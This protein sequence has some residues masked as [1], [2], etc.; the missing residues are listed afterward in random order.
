MKRIVCV[1]C[2]SF[3]FSL[4]GC[5]WFKHKPVEQPRI[6][7]RV[8]SGKILN[9]KRLK[10]GGNIVI[11]PFKAGAGVEATDELDKLSLMIVK[12]IADT[13][14]NQSNN[15]NILVSENANKADLILEGHITSLRQPSKLNRLILRKKKKDLGVK[16]KMIDRT[17]GQTLM[18]FSHTQESKN[19]K[20]N[21]QDLA[22][23]LGTN[24]GF[25]ILSNQDLKPGK[26]E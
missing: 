6:V 26:G 25:F 20:A 23:Q 11:L 15:F 16:G 8:N 24:I 2:V 22:Y 5:S 7:A 1:L 13:L 12:G 19:P 4:T 10:E 17:T 21:D 14:T 18:I 9:D 3:L